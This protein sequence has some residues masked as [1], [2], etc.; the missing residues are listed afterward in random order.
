MTVTIILGFL[1]AAILASFITS[2][3]NASTIRKLKA[4][5][6]QLKNELIS[7]GLHVLSHPREVRR[8]K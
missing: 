5:N 4:E 7:I 1:I 6:K 3:S 2:R 8:L